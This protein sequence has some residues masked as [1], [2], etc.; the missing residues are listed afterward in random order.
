MKCSS[1]IRGPLGPRVVA[2]GTFLIALSGNPALARF[3]E[4][5]Q[6]PVPPFIAK[7][8]AL[9]LCGFAAIEDWAPNGCQLCDP[10]NIYGTVYGPYYTPVVVWPHPVTSVSGGR[11]P[12]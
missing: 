6:Q 10:R 11:T 4:D 5:G 3:C 2:L 7:R 9:L 12:W 1:F 8:S